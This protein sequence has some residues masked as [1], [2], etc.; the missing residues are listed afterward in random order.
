MHWATLH[1]PGLRCQISWKVFRPAATDSARLSAASNS[2]RMRAGLL[3]EPESSGGDT[4]Q[5]PRSR[6]RRVDVGFRTSGMTGTCLH[7]RRTSVVPDV[8]TQIQVGDT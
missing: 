3:G 7:H 6:G 2:E 5:D 4:R 8:L 1:A